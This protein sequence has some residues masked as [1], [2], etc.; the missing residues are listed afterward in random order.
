M[1]IDFYSNNKKM[2]G[3]NLYVYIKN[4]PLHKDLANINKSNKSYID[5]AL[6]IG[7]FNHKGDN[8]LD[9]ILF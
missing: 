3:S 7:N 5:K 9:L 6:R 1:K 4:K 2:S 8:F